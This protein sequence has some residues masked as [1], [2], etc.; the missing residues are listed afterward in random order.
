MDVV[1]G[2]DIGTQSTKAIAYDV[3]TKR[4]VGSSS[5]AYPIIQGDGGQSEQEAGWYID[6]VRACFA[7]LSPVVKDAIV[8]IGVAAQQHGFVPLGRD[9][10]PVARVKLWN[11]TSTVAQCTLLTERLGGEEAVFEL[12]GNPIL[13]GYTLPKV[14]H[15]REH[16][17][18]AYERLAHILLPHDYVN[19]Y[20]TGS[21][22]S[23]AGDASGTA[24]YDVR[25]RLWCSEALS[26]VD[27]R[28][29]LL[30]MVPPLVGSAEVGGYVSGSTSRQLGIRE[31]IAVSSGA[32]DNMGSAIGCGCVEAGDLVLSMGTSGTLFGYSD[33]PVLDRQGRLAAFCS[34][35]GGYLPL[36]CTMNCTIGVE[37]VR[38]LFGSTIGEL[39]RLA[40]SAS[41]G[42]N[43]LTMVP[44]FSGERFPNLPA[45]KAAIGGLDLMNMERSTIARSA[46]ES[47]V[48]ATRGGLDAFAQ[49]GFEPK[50][51]I[52]TGGGAKSRLWRSIVCD[53]FALPL[54]VPAV[55]ESA[56]FGA[57]LQAL[58]AL[59]GNTIAEVVSSHVRYDEEQALQPNME[60]N[61]AYMDAYRRY[62][63]YVG[64]LTP[65]YQQEGS[66]D[67]L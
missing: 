52:L 13:P 53:V 46:Y 5:Y 7:Q 40:E 56:A 26:A 21:F 10:R 41:I 1:V 60:A 12:L 34:S 11:D 18:E 4:V 49:L 66:Q 29:N 43:G 47:A 63:A 64:A 36:L 22:W 57:A 65:L 3:N 45:A 42:S 59:E 19:Y 15:L 48:Y 62:Q 44:Y 27:E 55:G 35:S 25:R 58:W 33:E 51:I 14:L 20:L 54:A 38:T 23:E 17:R 31:G 28:R 6:A 16:Q 67:E 30:A 9:G 50:R 39:E 24:Y 2:L 37:R 32:G 8:A 61:A